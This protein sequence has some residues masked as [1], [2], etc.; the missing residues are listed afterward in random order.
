MWVPLATHQIVM[1]GLVPTI[2]PNAPAVSS[3]SFVIP[4]EVGTH[5]TVPQEIVVVSPDTATAPALK[6][7]VGS[8]LRGNDG[9]R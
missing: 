1:V 9:V 6:R 2:P 8:R 7:V 3:L 5:V 4:T